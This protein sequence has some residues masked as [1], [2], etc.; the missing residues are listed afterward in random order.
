MVKFFSPLAIKPI[1]VTGFPLPG[2]ESR[3]PKGSKR[4][5][6]TNTKKHFSW[7]DCGVCSI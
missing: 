6:R 1:I 2:P 7:V 3:Q 4:E 5:E